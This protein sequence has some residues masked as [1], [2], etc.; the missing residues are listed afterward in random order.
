MAREPLASGL[1]CR[2][3]TSTALLGATVDLGAFPHEQWPTG[4]YDREAMR[5]LHFSDVHLD[6]PFVGLPL[7]SRQRRREAIWQGFVRCLAAAGAEAVDLVTV[8]G[9]LWEDE[10][11]SENTRQAVA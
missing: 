6:R 3:A 2:I 9:D 7:A 5:I 10:N 4:F 11:V 8:G 1:T